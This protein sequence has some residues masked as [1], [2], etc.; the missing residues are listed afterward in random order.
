MRKV[1]DVE[2]FKELWMSGRNVHADG[3]ELGIHP[4]LVYFATRALNLPKKP[5]RLVAL[6]PKWREKIAH[7]SAQ[8]MQ[9]N[10][11]RL[12]YS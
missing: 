11:S 10:G 9:K 5:R 1:K 6:D 12:S 2:K 3:Q 4:Y 7:S 8:V